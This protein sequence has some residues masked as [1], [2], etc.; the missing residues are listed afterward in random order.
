MAR[1]IIILNVPQ[2]E[3]RGLLRIE[4]LFWISVSANVAFPNAN[5]RSA[6]PNVSQAELDAIKAGTV[7]ERPV[8]LVVP[9]N[10]TNADIQTLIQACYARASA[11]YQPEGK[12]YGVAWDGTA[13]SARP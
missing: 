10:M 4:A 6:A 2:H 13:W 5:A 12:Y 1:Q 9:D 7:V 11:Q 3:V 8:E